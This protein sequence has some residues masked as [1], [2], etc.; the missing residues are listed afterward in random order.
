MSAELIDRY[1]AGAARLRAAVA[2]MT[3][4]QLLAR[5]GPGAWST[6][7]VVVHLSDFEPVYADRIRRVAALDRPLLLGADENLFA[8]NLSPHERDV[9]EE[10]AVIDAL[11]RATAR[12]LR[13]LPDAAFARPCVHSERGLLTLEQLVG[14]AADHVTHHAGFIDRKRAVLA[15]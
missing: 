3:R 4:E 2:G 5:P 14:Y 13:S 9:E 11:R 1:H 12:L 15:G 8:A 6:L 7:E 10:L